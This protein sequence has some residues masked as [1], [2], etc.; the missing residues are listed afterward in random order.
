MPSAF[1]TM[2]SVSFDRAHFAG[3]GAY[4][5]AFEIVYWVLDRDYLVFRDIHQE[6]NLEIYKNFGEEGIEFAYPTQTLF[7]EKG[8]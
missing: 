1:D 7:M 4:S 3:Y 2:E 5:L 6:I 8:D